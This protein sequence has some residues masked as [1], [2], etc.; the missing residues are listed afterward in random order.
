MSYSSTKVTWGFMGYPTNI[1]LLFMDIEQLIGDDYN[2]GL[3]Q[4]KIQLEKSKQN[5]IHIKNYVKGH[6]QGHL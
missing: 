2:T 4:L 6:C 1:L 3:E 5:G